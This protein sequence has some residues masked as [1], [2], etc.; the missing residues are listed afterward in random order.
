MS[1]ALPEVVDDLW[2]RSDPAASEARFRDLLGR[3]EGVAP[4]EYVVEVL[5]QLARAQGLQQRF[6]EASATLDDAERRLEDGMTVG[7]VRVLL[8][9][10]RVANSAGDPGSAADRF[11]AAFELAVDEGTEYHAIDAAHMLGIVCEDDEAIAWNERALAM[12]EAATD[13][14]AGRWR[15]PLTN[16]LAWTYHG[17]GRYEQ[18]LGLFEA[19]AEYRASLGQPFEAG[20][21]RWSAANTL[22]HLG[23]FEEALVI[24]QELVDDAQRQDQPAEGY[25]H[26]EIG[27]CLLGL[28]RDDEAPS[29]FARAWQLLHDD[30]WLQRDE[31]DRLARLRE[32][33]R[34]DE[35]GGP[36]ATPG[37]K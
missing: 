15:G 2:D 21:A 37:P 3:A 26:E 28:G 29:H 27:E 12:A 6:V 22:R 8:E 25:T 33:G 32:L 11:R 16:N 20:I 19:D 24:L 10:G 17:L 14:R 35:R 9:R 5:T 4:S 31:P 23:Q 7:R 36:V 1:D 18:A 30:P 34:L 13:P